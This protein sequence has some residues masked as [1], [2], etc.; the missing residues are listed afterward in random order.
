MPT[1]DFTIE[2]DLIKTEIADS[3]GDSLYSAKDLV[4]VSKAIESLTNASNTLGSFASPIYV[5]EN[6][7]TFEDSGDLTD[8]VAVFSIAGGEASFAQI[9]FRNETDTSSTDIIAYMDNGDDSYGWVSLGITG[10]DF[11]DQTFG[12]TG[13]GDAYIFHETKDSNYDGNLVFATGAAGA[14]N[15][16]IFAAGGFDSGTTQMEITPGVNV[17]IEI[18]TASTSPSTG[19]LTVVGGVGIQGDVNIAGN[20]TFGGEGTS[21]ETNNLAVQDP[22]IYVGSGNIGDAVDLGLIAEYGKALAEPLSASVT[23]K[24]LTDDVATLTTSE[25]HDF[26]V[27]DIV[28]VG[29]I[30]ETFN[31]T[32][33]IT[34][35]TSD[36]FSYIKDANNVSPTAVSPAGTAGV[37]AQKKYAGVVRDASD[38]IIK[39]FKDAPSKPTNTV[40]FSEEGLTYASLK[41]DGIDANSAVFT[42]ITIGQVD[43][44]EIAHLNNVSSNIQTQLNAKAPSSSPSF[45]GTVV[46][47][48]TTSI[49]DVD[50]TEIGYL[51]GVTSNLQTQLDAK[52]ASATAAS[53]YAPLTQTVATPTFAA[54]TY[55]LQATDKDKILLASN[56]AT[57]GNINVPSEIFAVGSVLTIVQTGTGQL[58]LSAQGTTLNSQDSKLKLNGQYAS[59]QLICTATNTFLVIG[60]LVA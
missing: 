39:A 12:I 29:G 19:A 21:L 49:G 1:A 25:E 16:I 28:V 60:N 9:A 24:E 18:P 30:D 40:N 43:Q 32:F 36:T 23:N 5:G 50:A 26:S 22:L 57:T 46:L 37:S 20:I 35:V 33:I 2:I 14:E 8:P 41:V 4:Y 34:A 10:S 15:K 53:T 47:P 3:L 48:S 58:T 55:T 45:S 11:D 17:H 51:N 56:G 42:N 27:G 59:C 6:A 7:K 52:L 13:P 54:N 31:G 38:G 44:T